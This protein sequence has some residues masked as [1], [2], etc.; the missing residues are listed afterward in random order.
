LRFFDS[1]AA[2]T[3]RPRLRITYL[4]RSEFVLP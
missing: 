4:P 2:P 3:L 1:Q